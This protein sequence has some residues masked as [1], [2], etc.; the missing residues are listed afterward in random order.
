[1]YGSVI[2][3]FSSQNTIPLYGNITL[4]SLLNWWTSGLFLLCGYYEYCGYKHWCTC[5]SNSL[6]YELRNGFVHNSVWTFTRAASLFSSVAALTASSPIMMT[7]ISS[8]VCVLVSTCYFLFILTM[9]VMW[10]GISLWFWFAF[11]NN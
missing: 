10:G 9:L 7:G 8:S 11:P 3:S 6:G 1:M 2:H 5:V 4:F